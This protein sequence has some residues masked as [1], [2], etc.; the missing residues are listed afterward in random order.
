MERKGIP[1]QPGRAK[2]TYRATGEKP[3]SPNPERG[4]SARTGGTPPVPAEPNTEGHGRQGT[5]T[6]REEQGPPI[7]SDHQGERR[8]TDTPRLRSLVC[9]VKRCVITDL[10]TAVLL[11]G[12]ASERVFSS[13]AA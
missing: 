7:V 10:A 8:S 6:R 9:D 11:P 5:P 1:E 4:C 12:M 3:R 13:T 2:H